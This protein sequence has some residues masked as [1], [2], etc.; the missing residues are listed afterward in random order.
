MNRVER[1]RFKTDLAVR[2]YAASIHALFYGPKL[3][4]IF[5]DYLMTLHSII[6]ATEPLLQAAAGE[7]NRR[8]LAGDESCRGL[9]AY[10]EQH[11]E[12]EANHALWL[13]EDIES[14]G[15]AREDV[16]RRQPA[17]DVA[18]L[19]GS[20]YYWIY[21]HHPGFFLA[22]I[23]VFETHPMTVADIDHFK[24]L[25]GLPDAAFRTMLLHTELDVGH[26]A[27]F[28]QFLE[29]CALTDE[30]F[31]ALAGAAITA[32]TYSGKIFQA[33]DVVE[34]KRIEPPEE[35]ANKP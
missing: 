6:R 28:Y 33:L 10:L 13:L 31:D 3:K 8:W 19:V 17:W 27:E 23:A 29:T 16:L 11:I 26:T 21:H 2:Q 20:Q 4:R 32:C 7:A 18:A 15:I 12:Q 1:F 34:P 35:Q 9:A 30:I 5:P 24:Q 14:L 22:Y 25:T